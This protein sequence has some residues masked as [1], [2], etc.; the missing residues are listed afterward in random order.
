MTRVYVLLE[1]ECR[2]PIP[3]ITDVV[4]G[5]I[6]TKDGVEGATAMLITTDEACRIAL[7][8]KSGRSYEDDWK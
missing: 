6:Y 2:K 1:V 4:A 3:D 7:A 8:Q 5:R